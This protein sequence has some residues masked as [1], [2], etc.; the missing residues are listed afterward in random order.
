VRRR[1]LLLSLL[2]T[3][4]ENAKVAPMILYSAGIR[5]N[6]PPSGGGDLTNG[7]S[8]LVT[9][10]GFGS[11]SS[12]TQSIWDNGQAAVN[13]LDSQ[14]SDGWPNTG[15]T[16]YILKNRD[17][18]YRSISGPH[19]YTTR[20]LAG[21]HGEAVSAFQGYNVIPFKTYTKLGAS[22]Y[23]YWCF[24]QRCDP[25]W[26]FLTGTPPDANFKTFAFSQDGSPYELPNNWYYAHNTN[27]F[28]SNT[29]T[30]GEFII[31]DDGSSLVFPDQNS[32]SR[33]WNA[34]LN[35]HDVTNGWIRNEVELY[36][37]SSNSG[38]A[39][40]WENNVLVIDYAGPT[41]SYAGTTRTEGPGGYARDDGN[42][43]NYRYFADCYHDRQLGGIGRFILS[44]NATY[45]SSSIVEPQPYT[46]WASG[47]VTLTCNKG[48][49]STGTVHLHFRDP[50]NGHQYLGTRTIT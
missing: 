4:C 38:Y 20:F 24:Y 27:S 8:F 43:T 6:P 32:H 16:D 15:T 13:T 42:P 2:A 44:N 21:A 11:K 50:V 3:G 10:S 33:Y 35:P 39:K 14:W 28:E 7:N 41:D 22:C 12:S 26:A 34:A 30:T 37:T 48:K 18:G 40:M 46:A 36:V 9:G 47:S 45:A 31:N 49:L 23:S 19:A 17:S 1:T 5:P 25:N 29:D